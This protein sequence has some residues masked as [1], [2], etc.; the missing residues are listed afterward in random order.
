MNIII[1]TAGPASPKKPLLLKRGNLRRRSE[2]KE[3]N[4]DE[5]DTTSTPTPSTATSSGSKECGSDSIANQDDEMSEEEKNSAMGDDDEA[6]T[7]FDLDSVCTSPRSDIPLPEKQAG[8]EDGGGG[9]DAFAISV[10]EEVKK[11]DGLGGKEDEVVDGPG[12]QAEDAAPACSKVAATMTPDTFGA[13]SSP[14]CTISVSSAF[15]ADSINGKDL[16]VVGGYGDILR[17]LEKMEL[18]ETARDDGVIVEP[19]EEKDQ[20]KEEEAESE[21]KTNGG[22]QDKIRYSSTH[23]VGK[24]LMCTQIH[25]HCIC[26]VLASCSP[27]WIRL[28]RKRTNSPTEE[29]PDTAPQS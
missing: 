29:I 12:H 23:L 25:T 14:S 26:F 1:P 21:L 22:G 19:S 9:E 11:E 6:V 10:V 5:D 13:S 17:A 4:E 8:A 18:G 24:L 16:A 27:F 2:S 15:T 20:C 3:K 28:R 7:G